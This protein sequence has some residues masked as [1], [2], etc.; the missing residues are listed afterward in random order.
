MR[1]AI[2]SYL[3]VPSAAGPRETIEHQE[4][5][6]DTLDKY[7]GAEGEKRRREDDKRNSGASAVDANAARWD[8]MTRVPAGRALD[9]EHLAWLV[10]ESTQRSWAIAMRRRLLAHVLQN[11]P[12]GILITRDELEQL[13][14]DSIENP[15]R[16]GPCPKI[17]EWPPA[18]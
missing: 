15:T 6:M 10:D 4:E 16:P 11:L 13:R 18:R 17:A 9:A 5:H 3:P 1:E 7:A 8:L 14:A 2:R 12:A